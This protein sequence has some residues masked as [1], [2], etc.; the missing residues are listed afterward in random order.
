MTLV[1]VA[2][3]YGAGGSRVAPALAERLGVPFLGRPHL[4]HPEECGDEAPRLSKPVWE[5]CGEDAYLHGVILYPDEQD[6]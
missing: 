6:Q 2:A 3:F 1:T 5:L 4:P